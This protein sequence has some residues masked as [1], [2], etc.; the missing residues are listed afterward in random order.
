MDKKFENEID[1]AVEKYGDNHIEIV[2]M[3]DEVYGM[4]HSYKRGFSVT[5]TYSLEEI[6]GMD[7]LKEIENK[8]EELCLCVE[9]K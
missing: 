6:G 2:V 9:E 8:Y 5:D 3:G 1:L 7:V 4:Y